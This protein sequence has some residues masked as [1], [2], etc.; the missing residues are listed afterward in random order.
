MVLS[1]IT[2]MPGDAAATT[3]KE[4]KQV[5]KGPTVYA[6]KVTKHKKKHKRYKRYKRYKKHHRYH[7]SRVGDCWAMSNHLYRKYKKQGKKVRIIQYKTSMS[8]RHRSVQE[9]RNGGWF[10]LNYRSLGLNMIYWATKRKPGL[11]VILT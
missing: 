8:S 11:T 9:Y 1:V 2:L 6:K 10:D 7:Y 5:I 3:I 4:H